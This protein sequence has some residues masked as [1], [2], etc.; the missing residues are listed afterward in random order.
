MGLSGP[1]RAAKALAS[2]AV[3]EAGLPW[4]WPGIF[5][6]LVASRGILVLLSL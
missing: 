5:F 6:P 1:Q 2:K 4:S 3:L